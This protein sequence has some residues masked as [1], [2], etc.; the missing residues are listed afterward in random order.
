MTLN[1][2]FWPCYMQGHDGTLNQTRKENTMT[3]KPNA[4]TSQY[5]LLQDGTWVL[6]IETYYPLTLD[7]YDQAEEK[8]EYNKRTFKDIEHMRNFKVGKIY[9]PNYK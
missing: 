5:E 6:A 2:L 4:W 9:H 8:V 3:N 7:M 1:I